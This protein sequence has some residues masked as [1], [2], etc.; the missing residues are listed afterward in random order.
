MTQ[1]QANWKTKIV[2]IAFGVC[3]AAKTTISQEPPE[4]EP[5]DPEIAAINKKYATE[6]KKLEEQGKK[7]AEDAPKGEE[8]VVGLDVDFSKMHDASFDVPEFRMK[9]QKVAFDVPTST[10]KNRRIVW[11]NPEVTMTNKKVGQYP[12]FHGLTVRWKDIITKV[13]VT[14]MVR[15]EA[16]LDIPEF[17][18]KRTDISFDLPEIFRT[19]RVELRIPEIKVRTTKQAQE[20]IEAGANQIEESAKSFG[21]AQRKEILAVSVNRLVAQRA[22]IETEYK[23]AVADITNAIAQAKRVGADPAKLTGEGGETVNLTELLS[24]TNSQ[25]TEGL[26]QIDDAVATLQK[27]LGAP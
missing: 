25:F 11:D 17:K 23:K 4:Q 10:M 24:K 20:T 7:L 2:A 6:Y 14:K 15:R 5:V 12:E 22:T 21:A 1:S 9:R 3:L 27:E 26:K 18:M 19:R 8:N 13:P 16:N